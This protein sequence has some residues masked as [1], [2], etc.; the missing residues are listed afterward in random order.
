MR[1]RGWWVASA[2]SKNTIFILGKPKKFD[3]VGRAYGPQAMTRDSECD[4]EVARQHSYVKVWDEHSGN[5]TY[6][7]LVGR[8]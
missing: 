3:D 4:G 1:Y 8:V 6:A 2:A 5:E 7:A